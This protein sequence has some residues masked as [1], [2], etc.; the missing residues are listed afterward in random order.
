MK[1]FDYVKKVIMSCKTFD[2]LRVAH[3]MGRNV[4]NG[5]SMHWGKMLTYDYLIDDLVRDMERY[6]VKLDSIKEN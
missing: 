6:I 2:Q 1:H 4:V 5:Y 3:K